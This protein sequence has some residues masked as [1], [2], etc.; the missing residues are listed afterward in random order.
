MNIDKNAPVAI[1]GANGYV[2]SWIVKQ[3]LD[4][5]ATVHATVRD[6]S[7]QRKVGHLQQLADNAPGELK[8]FAADLAD[9]GAFD[10]AMVGCELVFHTASPFL[11]Q[12]VTDP[13]RELDYDLAFLPP[14]DAFYTF[15]GF[16]GERRRLP[17]RDGP[18]GAL[19]NTLPAYKPLDRQLVMGY[20]REGHEGDIA[21][22]EAAY[23][24][25]GMP[26]FIKAQAPVLLHNLACLSD[27]VPDCSLK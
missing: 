18:P 24:A 27:G 23:S 4:D 7:N 11:V 16:L 9:D 22:F 2:A 17:G 26:D 6:P 25:G 19:Y 12:T 8:F 10:Q 15:R 13:Q 5:G 1:T 21:R 14:S 3:L 20:W